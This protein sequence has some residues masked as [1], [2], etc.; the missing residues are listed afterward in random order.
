M[1][2]VRRENLPSKCASQSSAAQ[3]QCNPSCSFFRLVPKTHEK[4][5]A[6]ENTRLK[7][8]EEES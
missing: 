5:H 7:G 3:K 4:D 8:T 6:R 1:A 2:R